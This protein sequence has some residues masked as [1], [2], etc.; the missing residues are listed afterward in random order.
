MNMTASSTALQAN[1]H[2]S[3]IVTLCLRYWIILQVALT[4]ASAAAAA[5]LAAVQQRHAAAMAAL[6]EQLSMQ[7]QQLAGASREVLE[8]STQL[9]LSQREVNAAAHATSCAA[10][11][12]AG[13][14]AA[15]DE[16]SVS[17]DV[18]VG[19]QQ[20]QQH[21]HH[22]QQ[23][24]QH[25]QQQQSPGAALAGGVRRVGGSCGNRQ[26]AELLSVLAE[27]DAAVAQLESQL[28]VARAALEGQAE[29]PGENGAVAQVGVL[30]LMLL[31][32]MPQSVYV[33]GS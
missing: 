14:G 32:V 12:A 29:V 5:E 25:Q 23:Q 7:A 3:Y 27:R 26:H 30:A 9:A 24:Q 8:L 13:G 11:A 20:Q 28:A 16:S 10:A 21:Q 1:T 6:E 19:P 2:V 18:G 4:E 31:V 17:L 22:Q 33:I 15:E